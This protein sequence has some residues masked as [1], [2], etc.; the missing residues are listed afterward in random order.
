MDKPTAIRVLSVTLA[1]EAGLALTILAAHVA[2]GGGFYVP[3]LVSFFVAMPA[4]GLL[5]GRAGTRLSGV[6]ALGLTA[7]A[8][9]I[10]VPAF[11]WIDLFEHPQDGWVLAV[12]MLVSGVI[13]VPLTTLGATVLNNT[14]LS[15]KR[16]R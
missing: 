16:G 5:C 6:S 14:A 4:A 2:I 3:S 1:V 11:V 15:P 7:F 9:V 13:L 8:Y 12:A 10:S